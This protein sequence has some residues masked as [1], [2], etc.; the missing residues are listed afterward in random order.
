MRSEKGSGGPRFETPSG[1]RSRPSSGW[2]GSIGTTS[3]EVTA[4]LAVHRKEHVAQKV[5]NLILFWPMLALLFLY[6][7]TV[8]PT[9]LQCLTKLTNLITLIFHFVDIWQKFGKHLANILPEKLLECITLTLSPG[10]GRQRSAQEALALPAVLPLPAEVRHAP[11]E[12][13][14]LARHADERPRLHVQ[15][16]SRSLASLVFN[17]G[18]TVRGLRK[19]VVCNLLRENDKKAPDD[20]GEQR[21]R[22]SQQLLI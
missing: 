10:S 22:G 15:D 21:G 9:C 5:P 17:A 4:K 20:V 8:K 2:S 11:D 1:R 14:R 12:A 18:Q 19:L 6:Y 7:A 13:D 3:C 16:L